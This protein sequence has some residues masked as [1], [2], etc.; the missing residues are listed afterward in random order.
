M[1]NKKVYKGQK[2]LVG[3]EEQKAWPGVDRGK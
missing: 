1:D 2:A 3:M